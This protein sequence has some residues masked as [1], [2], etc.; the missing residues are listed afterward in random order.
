[1][2]YQKKHKNKNF[3]EAWNETAHVLKTMK[4]Y[5]KKME[6]RFP[7]KLLRMFWG[8]YKP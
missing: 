5:L 6:A 3:F 1:L 2:S 4:K 7:Q 8:G